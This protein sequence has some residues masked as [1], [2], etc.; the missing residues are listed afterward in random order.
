M[1]LKLHKNVV[2]PEDIL[3]RQEGFLRLFRLVIEQP[4]VQRPGKARRTANKAFM[5]FPQGFHVHAGLV[6]KT[7]QMGPG[8]QLDQVLPAGFIF[9]QQKKV[10][11]FAA[12]GKL[13]F[14]A[15]GR[16]GKVHL[17]AEDG[18]HL[19]LLR[20]FRMFL[21]PGGHG[22]VKA[23]RLHDQLNGP[24]EVA[25]VR[26]GYGRHSHAGTFGNE[27]LD[28]DCAV[29]QRVFRVIVKMYEGTGHE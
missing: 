17:A 23:V 29:Q 16:G 18:L 5:E 28:M 11:I 2:V 13:F 4:F 25:V 12:P 26:D 14:H 21:V 22:F 7:F 1:V 10:R 6:I 20:S 3:Q 24:E 8:Y 19:L 27:V 15:D 9:R